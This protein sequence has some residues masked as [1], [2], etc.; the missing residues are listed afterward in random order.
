MV[1]CNKDGSKELICKKSE[2]GFGK[3]C[4]PEIA[5]SST[6][7]LWVQFNTFIVEVACELQ[8]F[9]AWKVYSIV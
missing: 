6:E 1:P 8:P 5:T 3:I 2:V 7:E 4:I 9:L